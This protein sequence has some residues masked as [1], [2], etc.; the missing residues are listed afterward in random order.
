MIDTRFNEQ[1][2]VLIELLK[3]KGI[4]D[5]SVLN[6]IM[7]VPRERFIIPA[8]M[9]RAYEDSALPIDD[10]QT[11]SQPYTVAYMT[12]CLQV[13][14]N[15]KILEIG[16]GSGYQAAILSIMGAKIFTI[17]RIQSL[18]TKSKDLFKQLNLPINSRLSDGTL[19]WREMG[20]FD[21]IIITAG[22]PDVPN[23]L[24][25]QLKINGRMIAPIGDRIN[26]DMVLIIRKSESEFEKKVLDKFQFV[27]LIGKEGWNV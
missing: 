6:A 22:A 16:T 20:P 14:K 9:S 24:L 17:E 7:T 2:R 4:K 10:N 5:T 21:C 11:I 26:Q 27:P 19:G 12:E 8:F 1:K 25:S 3:T 23:T 13:K 15:D 18:Y